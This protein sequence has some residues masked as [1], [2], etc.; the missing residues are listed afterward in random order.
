MTI[1]ERASRLDLLQQRSLQ[2]GGFDRDLDGHTSDG[3]RK[4]AWL[5]LL[6]ASSDL[7]VEATQ[8][9][10]TL[11][12]RPAK[13]ASSTHGAESD[14]GDSQASSSSH[15]RSNSK[16]DILADSIHQPVS[17]PA[18][19]PRPELVRD[20]ER[21][22]VDKDG[23][24][25]AALD[26]L[27]LDE[28]LSASATSP[29]AITK[30]SQQQTEEWETVTSKRTRTLQKRRN[31][32]RPSPS[33]S[34][35]EDESEGQGQDGD[36]RPAI[37]TTEDNKVSAPPPQHATATKKKKKKS[38]RSGAHKRTSTRD[39][40]D[41]NG[42]AAGPTPA[43]PAALGGLPTH[44]D[45]EQVDK[46]IRRSFV[47]P[48]FASQTAHERQVRRKQLEEVVVLTLRRHP[49]LN[50]FQGYHDVVSVLVLALAMSGD[51]VKED[52]EP[53]RDEDERH[54][55]LLAV[56]RLSLHFVR[57]SMTH[58]LDPIMGQLKLVRNLVRAEDAELA[59]RVEAASALPFF[60]LSWL[61]TLFSHD[62]EDQR[63][64]QRCFDFVLA[65]GPQSVVYLCAAVV[66][67]VKKRELEGLDG[68][69]VEDQAMLHMVLSKLPRFTLDGDGNGDEGDEQGQ[70]GK[71]VGEQRPEAAVS[72]AHGLYADPD[73][74]PPSSRGDRARHEDATPQQNQE[75]VPLLHLLR[76]AR[77]L[78]EAHP[79]SSASLG[80]D[81]VM[82]P[83]SVIFTWSD[84][85]SELGSADK[86]D[87]TDA[88]RARDALAE[89]IVETVSSIVVDPQPSPPAFDDG[90]DEGEGGGKEKS[91]RAKERKRYRLLRYDDKRTK[92][93]V[94]GTVV[95]VVG[96]AGVVVALYVEGKQRGQAQ[97]VL[98][99]L[100]GV[101]G[102]LGSNM[103]GPGA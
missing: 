75:A 22:P 39:R 51:D 101:V 66:L 96:V 48:A 61:L 82:G 25:I 90:Y 18:S 94:L 17:T 34:Q 14:Q 64:V 52:G 93:V 54:G 85:Q 67:L 63:L 88:W 13:P 87:D 31:S 9:R 103:R 38:K 53:W 43:N 20:A 89:R 77:E 65:H 57:D 84:L 8:P 91:T 41:D 21:V 33:P 16:S 37:P 70:V 36:S 92:E 26:A 42:E 55:L 47:G 24:Q 102:W 40:P 62:L 1:Q 79:L 35:L 50:Y 49:T 19:S 72:D 86:A 56:E 76:K 100:G 98:A 74:D 81:K 23:W 12:K 15:T 97:D 99:V 29:H 78:M 83:K 27:S 73:V 7:T 46:D 5:F 6:H 44:R 30:L 58:D 3:F 28:P 45:E 10:N 32:T 80:A 71:S 95:A 60:A 2:S 11:P 68:D 69:E 4:A 59:G